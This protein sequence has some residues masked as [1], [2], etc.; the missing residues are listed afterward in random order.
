MTGSQ[1][2]TWLFYVAQEA[3]LVV[4]FVII[5]KAPDFNGYGTAW[6]I[7]SIMTALGALS[8]IFTP[9][10]YFSDNKKGVK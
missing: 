5:H 9:V 1:F 7:V 10:K 6:W 2:I 8:V 4:L 3:A